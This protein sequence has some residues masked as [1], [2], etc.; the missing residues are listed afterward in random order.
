MDFDKRYERVTIGFKD[1]L[2]GVCRGVNKWVCS[3]CKKR[4]TIYWIDMV[5]GQ[6]V[7]SDQCLEKA[8]KE[9][10]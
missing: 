10:K 2:V 5:T 3:Q 4:K 8:R 7:C 6:Y 1:N 9:K